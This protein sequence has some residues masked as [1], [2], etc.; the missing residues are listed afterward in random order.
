MKSNLSLLLVLL[1]IGCKSSGPDELS[2]ILPGHW[3]IVFPEYKLYSQYQRELYSQNQD[4]IVN[5]YGLKLIS[6]KNNGTFYETD[7]FFKAPGK[8]ILNNKSQFMMREGGKGFNPFKTS[9]LGFDNDTLRLAQMLQLGGEE[10]KLVWHLKKISDS[11]SAA[12]LFLPESNAWRK[13]PSNP[14]SE[15]AIKKRLIA[16]LNYYGNYFLL[17]GKESSYFSLARLPLPFQYYRHAIGMTPTVPQA[18]HQ[19]FY[20][21]EDSGKAYLIL[22]QTLSAMT[23]EFD[24]GENFVVEY[25]SFLKKMAKWLSY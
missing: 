17:I 7:S 10:I 9:F 22:S 14:E 24:W 12:N 21:S 3:L 6:F 11:D 19:F 25:G 16:M 15:Q 4:S 23:G 1:F 18:F 20:N 8:W 2:K 13:P 5:L